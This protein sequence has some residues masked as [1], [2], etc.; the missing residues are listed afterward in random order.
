MLGNSG[1]AAQL[2]AFQER[3]SS[4][5][6]VSLEWALGDMYAYSKPRFEVCHNTNEEFQTFLTCRWSWVSPICIAM[7]LDDQGME[8]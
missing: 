4:M 6:L 2:A 8:V 5:K 1:V 7:R 3:L